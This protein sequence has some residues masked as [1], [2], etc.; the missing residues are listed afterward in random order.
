MGK[1]NSYPIDIFSVFKYGIEEWQGRFFWPLPHNWFPSLCRDIRKVFYDFVKENNN[2]MGDIALIAITLYCELANVLYAIKIAEELNK[3][4]VGIAYSDRSLYFKGLVRNGVPEASFLERAESEKPALLRRILIVMAKVRDALLYRFYFLITKDKL[5]LIAIKKSVLHTEYL[6][7]LKRRVIRIS[8][9]GQVFKGKN[10]P[11]DQELLSTIEMTVDRFMREIL[12]INEKYSID[13]SPAQAQYIR[14]LISRFFKKTALDYKGVKNT[15]RRIKP[16]HIFTGSHG[17]YF[18]RLLGQAVKR[19]GGK[20]T[21]FTH[22]YT[23]FECIREI[24]STA[25]WN[26]VDEYIVSQEN[27]IGR[28]KRIMAEYPCARNNKVSFVSENSDFFIDLYNKK[29]NM[30][31]PESINEVMVIGFPYRVDYVRPDLLPDVVY[32][33]YEIRLV[34]FL[35]KHGYKVLYKKHP[36]GSLKGDIVGL[37]SQRCTV[38]YEPFEEVTDMGDAFLFTIMGT[39]TWAPAVCS[40]KPVIYI[41]NDWHDIWFPEVYELAKKRFRIVS[42]GFDERNRLI[43]NE[44]ELLEALAKKPEPPNTEYMETYFF[45]NRGLVNE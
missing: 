32:L 1:E 39:T 33:D 36:D 7:R 26:T 3:R 38:I 14:G 2:E 23:F 29:K 4:G 37:F 25:E 6:S 12:A 42:G 41:N 44:N 45:P 28:I 15:L 20:V 8:N 30:K 31:S 11:I 21:S 10:A 24:H 43:F 9:N 17:S 19:R 13:L 18:T 34:D 5:P 35:V 22:G 27:C 16:F 40:N